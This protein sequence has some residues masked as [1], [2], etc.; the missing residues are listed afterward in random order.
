MLTIAFLPI[1]ARS[2]ISLTL[3]PESAQQTVQSVRMLSKLPAAGGSTSL[4]WKRVKMS[5]LST[6]RRRPLGM[7]LLGLFPILTL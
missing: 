2:R 1:D 7:S 4:S 5:L 6:L 3:S